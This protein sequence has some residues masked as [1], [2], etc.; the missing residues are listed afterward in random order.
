MPLHT[1]YILFI[2]YY[3][4]I[5]ILYTRFVSPCYQSKT[6]W[7]Q[8]APLGTTKVALITQPTGGYMKKV[9]WTLILYEKSVGNIPKNMPSR[10]Y[11]WL[12]YSWAIAV[13][14]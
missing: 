13:P 2:F 8:V 1:T 6:T 9:R 12:T 10:F 3:N 14:C 4:N 11:D 5:I 7:Y